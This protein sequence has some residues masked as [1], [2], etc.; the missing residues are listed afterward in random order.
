MLRLRSEE[1][2]LI[3]EGYSNGVAC[4]LLDLRLLLQQYPLTIG[5][6]KTDYLQHLNIHNVSSCG[7]FIPAQ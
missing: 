5:V 6:T 3:E 4:V 1:T 7:R 2:W